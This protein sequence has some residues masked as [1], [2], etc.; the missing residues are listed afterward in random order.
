MQKKKQQAGSAA[1]TKSPKADTPRYR[2]RRPHNVRALPQITSSDRDNYGPIPLMTLSGAW[3]RKLGFDVGDQVKIEGTRNVIT[4][5]LVWPFP[6]DEPAAADPAAA[7]EVHY[8]RI[9]PR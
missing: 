3:M 8:A 5:S 1:R 9:E 7:P 6:P 2:S 4:I